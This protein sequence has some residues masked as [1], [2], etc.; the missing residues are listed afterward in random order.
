MISEQVTPQ[1]DALKACR[2]PQADNHLRHG[3]ARQS[4]ESPTYVSWQSMPA[5]SSEGGRG[6]MLW[7]KRN[8]G[9]AMTE[10]LKSC[11]FCG[12]EA[13]IEPKNWCGRDYIGAFCTECLIF[14]DS[15]AR[16]EDEAIAIWN[17]R[18]P[19]EQQQRSSH[20]TELGCGAGL[21]EYQVNN[22]PDELCHS[23]ADVLPALLDQIEAMRSAL[24]RYGKHDGLCGIVGGYDLCTCGFDAA[25][26]GASNDAS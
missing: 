2:A 13:K 3:H 15:R 6:R 16:T 18:A 25:L 24:E 8:G 9:S 7:Q 10:E 4:G 21:Y 5:K 17:T 19:S 20:D 23:A 14:Q 11:P 12:G 26:K 22:R 1:Q